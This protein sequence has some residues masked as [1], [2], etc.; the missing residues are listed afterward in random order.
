MESIQMDSIDEKDA[1]PILNSLL[2]PQAGTEYN[3]YSNNYY[4]AAATTGGSRTY[5]RYPY[6][7]GGCNMNNFAFDND[8]GISTHTIFTRLGSSAVISPSTDGQ[9]L[10]NY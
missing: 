6:I 8:A 7:L 4:N 10:I 3:V 9:H 1:S 2:S 5:D